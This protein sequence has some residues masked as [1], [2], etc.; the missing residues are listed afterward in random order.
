MLLPKSDGGL[1]QIGL[2]PTLIRVWM[3]S[4]MLVSR[5]WETLTAI[6]TIFGGPGMGAQAAAY[7]VAF[8]AEAAVLKAN[9]YAAGLL[10]LV[11]AFESVPHAILADMARA[12]G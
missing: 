3:R 5:A 7:Q 9:V 4:G 11:K 6:P 10:D 1:R 2:F 8:V 12:K